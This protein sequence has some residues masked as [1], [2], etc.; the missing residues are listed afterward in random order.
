MIDLLR[1]KKNLILQG[2]PGTGKTWLA[3]RLGY[4]LI[5]AKD[6]DRL[7]AVQ[8]QPSLS[9]EDFVRGWRPDGTGGLMLADG[10]FLEAVSAALSEPTRPF[11]LV[12][13]EINRG[14]PA[15]VLGELL[16]LIEDSKRDPSEA[17]RLAYPRAIGERVHVPPNLYLIGTMN[18]ADRSLALV[19]VA[20]R[21]RFAF[22]N[23]APALG[24]A[25]HGWCVDHG[26]PSVLVNTISERLGGLNKVI[27]DDR[28]LG[29]QFRVGHSFVTPISK[30]TPSAGWLAWYNEV[31]ETEI[32]PLLAEYWYDN[33]SRAQAEIAKLRIDE[34]G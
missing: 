27:T 14:N 15:Q 7:T 18:L 16:T 21:R 13:E 20:L 9:Y 17:L 6:P 32:G 19:D 30:K 34:Q 5:G 1:R 4:A 25:W 10:A 22:I 33:E 8:F 3:K 12:I 31:V 24:L 26:M 28:A 2:P 23:L 11:V 29:A